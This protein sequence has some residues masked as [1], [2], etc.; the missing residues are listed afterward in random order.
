MDWLEACNDNVIILEVE[1]VH[2]ERTKVYF[3]K[4]NNL[5]NKIIY[6]LYEISQTLKQE[7]LSGII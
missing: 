4:I 7:A 2:L 5:T 3:E 1:L 6:N